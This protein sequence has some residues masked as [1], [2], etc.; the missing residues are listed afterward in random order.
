[1]AVQYRQRHNPIAPTLVSTIPAQLETKLPKGIS[2][3]FKVINNQFQTAEGLTKLQQ[4]MWV[5]LS[6]PIG[7]RLNQCDFGSLLPLL[8]FEPWGPT[9]QQEL[10]IATQVAL[11]TWVPAVVV[12]NVVIDSSQI[13]SNYLK[14][15][16]MYYV[17][18][19]NAN[20]TLEISLVGPDI[21]ELPP[22]IFT[23]GGKQIAALRT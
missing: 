14:L 22:G 13:Q 2:I 9:L 5:T 17:K 10:I 23:I 21:V 15:T 16:I 20:Q 8:I 19:T 3:P 6:T 1:M 18:G 11:Q 12:T 4:D 7:R